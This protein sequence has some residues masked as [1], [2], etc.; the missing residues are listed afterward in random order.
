M[1]ELLNEY[2]FAKFGDEWWPGN[3]QPWIGEEKGKELEKLLDDVDQDK[4]G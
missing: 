4:E 3:A 1:L 2:G